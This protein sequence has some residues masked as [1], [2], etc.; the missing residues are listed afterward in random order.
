MRTFQSLL[1]NQ[2]HRATIVP[3]R[4]RAYG[5]FSDAR[6][7]RLHSVSTSCMRPSDAA[8]LDSPLGVNV[9]LSTLQLFGIAMIMFC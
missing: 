5:N 4:M 2:R 8:D 1:R 3:A 6:L 9:Q 7:E